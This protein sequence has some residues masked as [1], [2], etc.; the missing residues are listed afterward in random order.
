[1]ALTKV[2]KEGITGVSNSS[3]ATAITID[4]SEKVGIGTT[5]GTGK[6]TVQDSSLPK[7][8]ANYQG[9]HHLELGVGGSG[10]GFAMTTGHFMTFNHQPV[11]NAGSDTNLTE[12]MRIDSTGAVM[13]GTTNNDVASSSGTGNEGHVLPAG[14]PAQH[15]FSNSTCLDLNRKTTDGVIINLRKNGSSVGSISTNANSLPSDK[16]FKRDIKDLNIGLD[17]VSQLQP[18]SFNLIVDDENSPVMYGLVAQDLE[19]ALEKVGVTKNS[20]WI[21]QHEEKNDAKESDYS[22]DYGKLI[23]ILINAIKE[24]QA[25]VTA[26]ESK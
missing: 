1:M 26:L 3:D 9:T 14:A 20:A 11:A 5:S 13:V 18:K 17:L 7:I 25:K 24:L 16:N 10:C 21:L 19:I 12:R 2:G 15:A 4:S 23:P 8:Q 6:L 22:L